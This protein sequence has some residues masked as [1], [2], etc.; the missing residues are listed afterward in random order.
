MTI[1]SFFHQLVDD[2]RFIHLSVKGKDEQLQYLKEIGNAGD[3]KRKE[4]IQVSLNSKDADLKT[5]AIVAHRFI[6]DEEVDTLLAGLLIDEK[7]LSVIGDLI[8]VIKLRFPSP[9]I[10]LAVYALLRRENIMI[11]VKQSLVAYLKY[12]S[13]EIEQFGTELAGMRTADPGFT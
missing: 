1:T 6:Y 4:F 2:A 7:D 11:G 9:A 5:A 8:E 10:R 12:Y 13:D 3:E